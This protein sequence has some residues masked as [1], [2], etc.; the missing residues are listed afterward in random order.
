MQ[1]RG[2]AGLAADRDAPGGGGPLFED[3]CER[4][5]IGGGLQGQPAILR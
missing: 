3:S 5:D 2:R 1:P 4:V